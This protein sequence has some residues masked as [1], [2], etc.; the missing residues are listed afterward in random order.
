MEK[1][2]SCRPVF[3]R[4]NRVLAVA[5]GGMLVICWLPLLLRLRP[6]S[7]SP[8]FPYRLSLWASATF[9]LTWIVSAHLVARIRRVRYRLSPTRVRYLGPAGSLT[10]PLCDIDSVTYCRFPP[11][12]GATLRS[13]DRALRVPFTIGD[14]YDFVCALE[15]ILNA[16]NK[17]DLTRTQPF[18]RFKRDAFVADEI[19]RRVPRD[20]AGVLIPAPLLVFTGYSVAS[21]LWLLSPACCVIWAFLTFLSVIAVLPLWW[22]PW[23]LWL[24]LSRHPRQRLSARVHDGIGTAV[25]SAAVLVYLVGGIAFRAFCSP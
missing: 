8:V 15:D 7:I 6:H 16:C 9:V 12:S 2:F 23:M 1:T 13:A 4:A 11:G 17:E 5:F 3:L 24:F 18:L 22:A 20:A 21:Y 14:L 19:E 25:V 10:L